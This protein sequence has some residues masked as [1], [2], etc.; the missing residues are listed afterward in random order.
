MSRINPIDI[1][2]KNDLIT[3]AWNNTRLELLDSDENLIDY[4]FD[5]EF[6]DKEEQE[7]R[8]EKIINNVEGLNEKELC[9]YLFDSIYSIYRIE[10]LS[11]EEMIKIL[12][13]EW[14]DEY[15]NRIGNTAL[16]IKE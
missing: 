14:G 2:F 8:I 3:I 4:F 15:V 5:A 13:E 11:D 7:K 9:N 12:R 1:I 10:P 16:I 6:Y